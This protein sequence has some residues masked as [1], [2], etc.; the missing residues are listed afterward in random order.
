MSGIG[1]SAGVG[2]L[3]GSAGAT[4]GTVS[5]SCAGS[6]FC[7][8]YISFPANYDWSLVQSACTSGSGTLVTTLCAGTYCGTCT[9]P[10][11]LGASIASHYTTGCDS[12]QAACGGTF[13]QN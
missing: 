6:T 8:D 12:A 5:R 1:A 9:I 3:A 13:T 4:G 2:G 11:G 7:V 10:G